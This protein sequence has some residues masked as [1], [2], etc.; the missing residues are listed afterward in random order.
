M[1]KIIKTKYRLFEKCFNLKVSVKIFPAFLFEFI[2]LP[3]IITVIFGAKLTG[4][5]VI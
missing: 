4:N 5:K 2:L 3:C 1:F